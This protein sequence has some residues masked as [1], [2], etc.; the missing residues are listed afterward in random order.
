MKEIVGD[1]F[2]YE[3]L[4]AR[5]LKGCTALVNVGAVVGFRRE[6]GRGC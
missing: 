3:D 4:G 1:A 2:V 6:R 5:E